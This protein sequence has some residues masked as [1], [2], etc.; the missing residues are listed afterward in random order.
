R[1]AVDCALPPRLFERVLA[2]LVQL[3]FAIAPRLLA[4]RL[5]LLAIRAL[6]LAIAIDVDARGAFI[7]LWQRRRRHV[8]RRRR[9]GRRAHQP[10]KGR[11]RNMQSDPD[12]DV[13]PANVFRPR[14]R[15]S[16]FTTRTRNNNPRAAIRS[17]SASICALLASSGV[18]AISISTRPPSSSTA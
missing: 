9:V 12:H 10:G 18:F 16:E 3:I 13:L 17:R 2:L 5:V 14:S 7:P 4:I 15:I 1:E 11:R 8:R 6:L